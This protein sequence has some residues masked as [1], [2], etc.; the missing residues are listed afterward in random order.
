MIKKLV[1]TSVCRSLKNLR[2]KIKFNLDDLRKIIEGTGD[3]EDEDISNNDSNSNNLYDIDIDNLSDDELKKIIDYMSSKDC[4]PGVDIA[5]GINYF[6]WDI[7]HTGECEI[8]NCTAKGITSINERSL[9]E[10]DV[11]IR[12][13]DAINIIHK[14]YKSLWNFF[15]KFNIDIFRHIKFF[16]PF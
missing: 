15:I 11:F 14:F 10:F 5:G 13:N 4:F 7:K 6:L 3:D 8:C 2:N 12:D 16:V 1:F 9:N